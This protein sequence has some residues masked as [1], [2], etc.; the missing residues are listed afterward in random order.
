M[1]AAL[2]AIRDMLAQL[3]RD[4]SWD[5]AAGALEIHGG[6]PPRRPDESPARRLRDHL[7]A[8]YFTRWAPPP[9]VEEQPLFGRPDGVPEFVAGLEEAAQ[10]LDCWEPGFQVVKADPARGW[11]YVSNWQLT[12]F[13][14]DPRQLQPP[15]AREG[16]EVHVRVPCARPNLSAGFF[17]LVGRAGPLDPRLPH[18]KIYLNIAPSLAAPL[19]RALLHGREVERLV[20]EAKVTN[21]PGAYCR[22]DTGVVYASPPDVEKMLE[23]VRDLQ[24]EHPD[25]FRDGTPL[26][27][28]EVLR[29]VALAES[30]VAQEGEVAESYGQH[31]CALVANAVLERLQAG[32]SPEEWHAAVERAFAAEGLSLGR[33]WQKTLSL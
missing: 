13:V 25:G 27:T 14:D 3:A 32:R 29:G 23:L 33:P 8:R 1:S 17:Y 18:A 2:E 9:G 21:D 6:L 19:V 12:L 10:G 28:R 24:R 4:L 20:F 16:E 31:R 11:A 15:G 7:Y 30:P 5:A 26:F 22:A